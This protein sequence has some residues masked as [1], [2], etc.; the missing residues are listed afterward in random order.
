MHPK[1]KREKRL[2]KAPDSTAE[3][4][5]GS[6]ARDQ[7][8]EGCRGRPRDPA[9]LDP[10]PHQPSESAEKEGGDRDKSDPEE[11]VGGPRRVVPEEA[12]CAGH[13]ARVPWR[14]PE[15]NPN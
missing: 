13:G 9:T 6:T 11:G 4:P 10:Q 8:E 15:E 5:Q 12:A 7:G 2:K 1:R 3:I 14:R